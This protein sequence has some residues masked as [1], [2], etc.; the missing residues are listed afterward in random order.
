MGRR[1]LSPVTEAVSDEHSY[2]QSLRNLRH[3]A[4]APAVS[5]E[6]EEI[7]SFNC[8]YCK[9]TIYTND[10]PVECDFCNNAYCYKCSG[11]SSKAQYN[12]LSQS[13][14]EE[15]GTMWFCVHCRISNPGVKKMLVRVTKLEE[16]QS[17]VL[18]RLDSLEQQNEGLDEKIRGAINEQKEIDSRKLNIMCFGLTESTEENIP[19][20]N[21]DEKAKLM[22]IIN[23]VLEISEEDFSLDD[24]PVRIGKFDGT[25]TRPLKFVAKN[26]SSK[27]KLLDAARKKLKNSD[28]P[29]YKRLFFKP[30][31][32]INQR[33][34]ARARRENKSSGQ[35]MNNGK[36]RSTEVVEEEGEEPF[37]GSQR[38]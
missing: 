23:E 17:S 38:H 7:D 3:R 5:S 30:D 10:P 18:E 13:A 1:K 27:K 35:T 25:K 32:T 19:A 21:A 34:E 28:N 12:K 29:E 37:R 24:T 22:H 36:R 6:S 4:S 26:F 14:K 31:L 9:K 33:A 16:N 2:S 11:A 8:G 20:R 15:D